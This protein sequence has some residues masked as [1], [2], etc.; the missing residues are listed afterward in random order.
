[1]VEALREAERDSGVSGLLARA[2][3]IGVVPVVSWRYHDPA[4]LVAAA[5]GASPSERW[6]PSMGGNTPQLLVNR[7]ASSILAGDCDVALV[8]GGESYR[9]R[10]LLRRSGQHPDWTKQG[11][12]DVP[13][14]GDAQKLDMGHPAE[15]AVGVF[16]P[17]S[18]YPLFESALRHEAGRT[19]AEQAVFIGDLWA[20]FSR[21]AARNPSAW[22][23]VEYTSAQI[24]EVTPANRVI[25]FPYTKHM[26]SNPDVDMASGAIIMSAS[27]ADD[28][29][30]PRDR[31]VF[32]WSGTD[33]QDPYLSERPSMSTSSSMRVAGNAAL[34]L[35]GVGIDDIAHLDVYS[36]FPSAV[37]IACAELDIDVT[38]QLTVYGGL[39]FAGGPWNNPVGHAIAAMVGV[40]REDAGSVGLVTANGGNIQKH[41]FGVYSGEPPRAGRF[42]HA[43]PQFAIDAA[44]AKVEVVQGYEGPAVMESFTVMHERDGS[45][46]RAHGTLRTP[47]GRRA[48][49]V[50]SAPDLMEL[51]EVEDVIGRSATL[52]ADAELTL[53]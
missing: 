30:V 41:A 39:P 11:D 37:E 27:T 36:C 20:G 43:H 29:G 3:V 34:E 14:W 47:D 44:E 46:S 25:G 19:A 18:C 15:A 16:M 4:Q 8:T 17:T 42:Q 22:N 52:A 32:V 12:G 1:M 38:R 13:T 53:D 49:G 5:V 48:W 23:A 9:T 33:G 50:S 21:V 45:R 35:A 7:A 40:L 51:F 2:S 6:Y 28:L 31:W 26:V 10:Q 24:S